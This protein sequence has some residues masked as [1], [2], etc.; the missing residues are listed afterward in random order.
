V[1]EQLYGRLAQGEAI[2]VGEVGKP[3]TRRLGWEAAANE[4]PPIAIPCYAEKIQ[5]IAD[6]TPLPGRT[7]PLKRENFFD[8]FPAIGTG[9]F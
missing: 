6:H 8:E 3:A 2:G 5:G 1:L 9:E 4:S 7:G